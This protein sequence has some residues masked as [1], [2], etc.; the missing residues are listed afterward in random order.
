MS[1]STECA[2]FDIHIVHATC[3]LSRTH[4]HSQINLKD[5]W[6]HNSIIVSSNLQYVSRSIAHTPSRPVCV[7][8]VNA[9]I[10]TKQLLWAIKTSN[11]IY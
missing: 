10:K 9:K 6:G 3:N 11:F 7:T 1:L 4:N 5:M 8:T 2:D